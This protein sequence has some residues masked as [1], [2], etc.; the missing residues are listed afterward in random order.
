MRDT[1]TDVLQAALDDAIRAAGSGRPSSPH[2]PS[3]LLLR[4]QAARRRR[5]LVLGSAV[6]VAVVSVLG[7]GASTLNWDG[8]S[9]RTDVAALD[10]PTTTNPEQSDDRP[11]VEWANGFEPAPGVRFITDVGDFLPEQL[12]RHDL[13]LVEWRG[14]EWFVHGSG[15]HGSSDHGAEDGGVA[16]GRM[17]PGET[18]SDVA[19][20]LAITYGARPRA[21]TLG[22]VGGGEAPFVEGVTVLDTST[23]PGEEEDAFTT[24]LLEK[25]GVEYWAWLGYASDALPWI[26][27]ADLTSILDRDEW[28]A[29]LRARANDE[30]PEPLLVSGVRGEHQPDSPVRSIGFGTDDTS[31]TILEHAFTTDPQSGR[32]SETMG[33]SY[34]KVERHG[35]E[36]FV[37]VSPTFYGQWQVGQVG[38]EA[39]VADFRAWLD[40]NADAIHVPRLPGR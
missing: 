36:W 13:A 8:T 23:R 15:D 29:D 9:G 2:D 37:L 24:W 21:S 28:G 27:R 14:Q 32:Q 20:D 18:L 4:G 34:V 7:I 39:T 26:E 22:L 33:A 12:D 19:A 10:L 38:S 25:D 6:T 16:S 30:G 11:P 3:A 35:V 5:S 17:K 40:A 1:D 31:V